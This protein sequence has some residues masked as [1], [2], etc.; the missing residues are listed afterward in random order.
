MPA[1]PQPGMTEYRTLDPNTGDVL[2]DFELTRDQEVDAAIAA[3]AAAFPD[4]RR[5]PVG[6]RVAVLERAAAELERGEAEL[7]TLMALEMGKP[8]AQ[9]RREVAKCA[10]VC[11][12]YAES[13]GDYLRPESASPA[14]AAGDPET[15]VRFD[16]LGPIFAIM[17]WNF[18][19][20]QVFR[21]AAPALAAGNVVLLKHA[22]NTPGTAE[23]VAGLFQEAG[24]P[25][26]VFQNLFLGNDQAARVIEHPAVRGVTITGS[27]RAGREVASL[28]GRALKPTV[29]ELG[30]SDPFI[31]FGDADIPAAVEQG[32]ASRCLN[33][34]QSCIA[35]KRFLVEASVYDDVVSRLVT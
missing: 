17:P 27:T 12:H 1:R 25:A 22:P 9:G 4:W 24:A 16:A 20:W 34:G 2:E 28:A 33:S 32:A 18:P 13:A 5:R 15:H 11:R 14:A 6:E 3:A 8:V 19:L 29:T 30:G 26:G 23:A 21:F 31:I 35:A 10:L 7:A